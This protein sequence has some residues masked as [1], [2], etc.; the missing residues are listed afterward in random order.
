[1]NERIGE[2]GA[3]RDGNDAEDVEFAKRFM[4]SVSEKA[5][6]KLGKYTF[7]RIGKFDSTNPYPCPIKF[8]LKSKIIVGHIIRPMKKILQEQETL[9]GVS[10]LVAT[11]NRTFFQ[12]NQ[13][14]QLKV[15]MNQRLREG[16][17]GL[18]IRKVRGQIKI[19]KGREVTPY[20]TPTN[21]MSTKNQH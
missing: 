3:G 10:G 2:R 21:L 19:L 20:G 7:L 8:S 11:S 6:V 18:F 15:K 16:E 5:T 13:Y 12:R 9:L 14:A 17:T 4:N 1:M